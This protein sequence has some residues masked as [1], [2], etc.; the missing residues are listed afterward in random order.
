MARRAAWA[1]EHA[2]ERGQHPLFRYADLL[3]LYAEAMVETGDLNGAR[4]I[5][6]EI[7]TRAAQRAQGPGTAAAN[8][9][10]TDQ[11]SLDYVGVYKIGTVSVI[12]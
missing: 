9:R 6:N 11:R 7:R 5:V 1:G 8:D 4:L 10:G 12:P 3:L 2:A